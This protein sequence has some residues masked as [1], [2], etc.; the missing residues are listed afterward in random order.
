M[1]MLSQSWYPQPPPLPSPAGKTIRV[2]TV[3]ELFAAAR[4]VQ[5]GETIL[6]ADG[7]YMM[8]TV[9]TITTDR[10]IVRSESGDRDK[11][12]LDGADSAHG[13]L[14]GFTE[15]HGSTVADLT[16]QNIMHNGFKFN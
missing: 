15:C 13:E 6:I 1:D 10:V 9:F 11:V 8:P 5:P 2:T 4:N 3:E 16:I 7:H 14:F 12:V